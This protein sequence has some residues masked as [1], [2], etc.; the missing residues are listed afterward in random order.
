MLSFEK[1]LYQMRTFSVEAAVLQTYV[2]FFVK[3]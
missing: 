3:H 1:I 2:P